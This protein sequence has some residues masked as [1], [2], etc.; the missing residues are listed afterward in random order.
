MAGF[1][2]GSMVCR[3]NCCGRCGGG[4][5]VRHRSHYLVT[6]NLLPDGRIDESSWGRVCSY[7]GDG[8]LELICEGCGFSL[9]GRRDASGDFFETHG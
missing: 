9:L 5:K 4:L 7:E 6:Y 2:L 3:T 1:L 8:D